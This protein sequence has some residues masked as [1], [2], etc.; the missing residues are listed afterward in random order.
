MKVM[1]HEMET[2]GK[3]AQSKGLETKNKVRPALTG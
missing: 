3:V 1:L 2:Q